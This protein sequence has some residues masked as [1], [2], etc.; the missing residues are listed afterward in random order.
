MVVL[1]VLV[2]CRGSSRDNCDRHVNLVSV[3]KPISFSI[4]IFKVR[5]KAYSGLP[6]YIFPVVRHYGEVM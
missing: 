2:R 4:Y 1:E 3:G 6:I 5:A